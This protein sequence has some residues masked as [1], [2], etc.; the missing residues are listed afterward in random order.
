M[1]LHGLNEDEAFAKVDS[2]IPQSYALGRRCVM[3]ITGKGIR[4]HPDEDILQLKAFCASKYR[5]G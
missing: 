3:I 2:F 4:V 1:D 5:N